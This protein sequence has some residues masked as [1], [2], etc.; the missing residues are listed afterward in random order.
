MESETNDSITGKILALFLRLIHDIYTSPINLILV[1]LI[2][3]LLVKLFLLKRKP[4]YSA[5][6]VKIQPEL[7]KMPKQDLTVEQLRAYNG[8]D[9]NGRILTA[10]YGDIFDVS[11]RS[12]LYG[13]GGS[14]SLFA[15]RDATRSLSKMQLTQ[16]LFTDDYDDLTDLTDNERATARSWHEDFREKYDIVGRLL[17]QGEKPSVY[18]TEESTVDSSA[19]NDNKK[20]E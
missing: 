7:P 8:T 19:N 15:G 4:T 6:S 9:S 11:R 10:I 1:V 13:P 2:I 14:Y 3:F 12:D 5:S 16:S 18:P 20:N 17:K